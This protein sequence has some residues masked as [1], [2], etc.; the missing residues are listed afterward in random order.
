M[1]YNKEYTKFLNNKRVVLVG[2]SW[3]IKQKKQG[4][5]ID[6]YDVVVRMNLGYRIPDKLISCMGKKMDV[7]YSSLN[8]YYIKNK[9]FT[10][11]IVKELSLQIKWF[12]LTHSFMHKSST[13]NLQKMNK[14]IN[15]PIYEVDKKYYKILFDKTNKK[16]SCGIIT[17]FDLLQHNIKELYITGITFYDTKIIGK[18]RIYYSHYHKDDMR[19]SS[20]PFGSHN[21][22]AELK[23]L[24]KFYK[25]DKRITCDDI[26]MKIMK[27]GRVAVAPHQNK[28]V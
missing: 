26:L 17:I 13:V 27:Q 20:R 23:I 7:L 11:K 9:Y 19:Y 10:K 3:H 8:N 24:K 15:I 2:P 4:K 5:L 1:K 14:N 16:L 25:Q 6:S 22:N 28:K 21:M 18:R 12:C